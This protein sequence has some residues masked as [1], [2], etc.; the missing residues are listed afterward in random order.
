MP[1]KFQSFYKISVDNPMAMWYD[2]RLASVD[3]S[4]FD[5]VMLYITS[6]EFV[7]SLAVI[8]SDV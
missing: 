1:I 2:N 8:A 4:W 6:D 7:K 5:F 3:G